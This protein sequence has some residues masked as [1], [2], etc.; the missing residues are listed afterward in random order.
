MTK[1]KICGIRRFE[2]VEYVNNAKPDF[3]GFVFAKS[4]RQV[5][6]DTAKALKEK[7][8]PE[9][10]TVGVF[11]NELPERVAELC[12]SGIIDFAQLHGNEDLSYINTLKKLTD[13]PVI[14]AV[15]AK[16]QQDI[17]DAEK[18]PVD[19]LLLDTYNK[20]AYGGTGEVFNWDIIPKDLS[21]PF[22]LAGGLN[23]SNLKNAVDTVNP[24][25]LDLSSGVE[26]DGVKDKEKIDSVMKIID[27]INVMK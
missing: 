9:I 17:T 26:T 16:C 10:K 8:N 5:T 15:R 14:K 2:D 23:S 6:E 3:I 20:D 18:L 25:C 24:Y 22:F 7:L 12:N 1:I 4:K 27:E 11:V 21:K 19:Y 13:K